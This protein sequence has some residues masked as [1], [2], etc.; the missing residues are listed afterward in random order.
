MQVQVTDKNDKVVINDPDLLRPSL[1][2]HSFLFKSLQTKQFCR[3]KKTI[4]RLPNSVTIIDNEIQVKYT[5]L[6]YLVERLSKS[7]CKTN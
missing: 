2:H 3:L 1:Y 5:C 6:L 4:V 7:R